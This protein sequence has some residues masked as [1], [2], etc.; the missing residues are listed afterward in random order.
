MYSILDFLS[1]SIQIVCNLS[2]AITFGS[3]ISTFSSC[4]LDNAHIL[5][6]KSHC[7]VYLI[8]SVSGKLH[9]KLHWNIFLAQNSDGKLNIDR[10]HTYLFFSPKEN[11]RKKSQ[12][13][14]KSMN[15]KLKSQVISK[16][17][18]LA[19]NSFPNFWPIKSGRIKKKEDK[20]NL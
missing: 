19:F 20:C 11:K 8:Y 2:I 18:L 5:S 10:I 12:C 15:A 3:S 14:Q 13:R 7:E 16:I 6:L 1:K 4:Y 9:M 17:F